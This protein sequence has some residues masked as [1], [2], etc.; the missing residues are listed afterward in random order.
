MVLVGSRLR[1]R[2]VTPRNKNKKTGK[3]KKA[4]KTKHMVC[5]ITLSAVVNPSGGIVVTMS[6]GIDYG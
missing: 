1:C 3:T 5:T 4:A 2:N 6:R